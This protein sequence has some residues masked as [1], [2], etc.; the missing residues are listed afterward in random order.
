MKLS[1]SQRDVLAALAGAASALPHAALCAAI[2]HRHPDTV[3]DA[4]ASLEPSLVARRGEKRTTVY[5]LTDAGRVAA[6]TG[7]PTQGPPVATTPRTTGEDAC[8]ARERN[9]NTKSS[10]EIS[11]RS[12][13]TTG[14]QGP[15]VVSPETLESLVRML[16]RALRRIEEIEARVS[17]GKKDEPVNFV[18]EN[19]SATEEEL[20]E[21]RFRQMEDD[22]KPV[23]KPQVMRALVLS[24]LRSDAGLRASLERSRADRQKRLELA[25]AEK[26]LAAKNAEIAKQVDRELAESS[27]RALDA[28]RA[29]R[30]RP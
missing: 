15:P 3:R 20:V 22:G 14:G 9:N 2:P 21:E 12:S 28:H 18:V 13:L 4:R 29:A 27:R 1:P 26:E 10:N 23:K 16:D 8:L 7:G 25:Q 6:A 19:V 11:S 24:D 30:R 5:E 17:P